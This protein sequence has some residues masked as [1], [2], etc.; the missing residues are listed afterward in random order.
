MAE[1]MKGLKRTCRCAEVT[2][3]DIGKKVTLMGW[4]QIAARSF[5]ELR[6]RSLWH[7]TEIS[8]CP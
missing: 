7:R 1:S 6:S 8:S 4:V 2:K 3:A 5:A